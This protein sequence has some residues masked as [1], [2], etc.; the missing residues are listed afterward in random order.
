MAPVMVSCSHNAL[1]LKLQRLVLE[2]DTFILVLMI[3]SGSS[4]VLE[5]IIQLE[6]AFVAW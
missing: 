6:V 4:P 1:I 5:Q 2:H 3:H